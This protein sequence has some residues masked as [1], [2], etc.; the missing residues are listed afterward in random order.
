MNLMVKIFIVLTMIF[1]LHAGTGN[2]DTLVLRNGDKLIGEI[3]NKYFVVRGPYSQI[4]VKKAFCKNLTMDPDQ[5]FIGSLKTINNDFFAG[6]ILDKEI[7]I[8]L[9]DKTREIVNINDLN[10]IFFDISGPSYQVLTTIFTMENG[11]RFSGKWLNPEIKIQTKYMTATY[12][13]TEIN[14]ID[15]AG[16]SPDTV[17]LLLINGDII[18]GKLLLDEIRI[19][20]DSV[21]QLSADRTKFSSIQFNARKLL[22]KEYTGTASQK[23][24]D[25]DEVLD[26]ADK[27][28]NIPWGNQVDENGFSTGKIEMKTVT[29]PE[30]KRVLSED[31]DGDGVP[32]SSDKCPQTPLGAEVD[33]GGCWLTQD[34]LFDFDSYLVKRAYYPVLDNVFAV[35]KKNPMLKIEIQGSADNIGASEYN[36]ILS[37]KRTRAV[38]KYLVE[39]GIDP[40]R[41]S[42]VGYGSTRQV[43]S[44][45]T[46]GGRALNRRIDFLVKE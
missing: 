32:D 24:G 9:T 36:Q 38:K 20:P 13:A 43:A 7:Q 34:I 18:L 29:K 10:L 4:V 8:L 42:A 19:E 30:I 12:M 14:R 11:D 2:T 28:G 15:F 31:K 21:A 39:K 17:K 41:L 37:E 25:R 26:D 5:M 46:E 23:D 1:F 6:T 35:L 3:Q 33:G 16:D 40:E 27:G 45:E 22:L 44:N